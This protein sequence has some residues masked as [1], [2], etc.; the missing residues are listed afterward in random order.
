M[1]STEFRIMGVF[2]LKVLTNAVRIIESLNQRGSNY[3]GLFI[4]N[5]TENL[6]GPEQVIRIVERFDCTYITCFSE[7]VRIVIILLQKFKYYSNS[8]NSRSA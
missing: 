5:C 4:R 1:I 2:S 3:G 6:T 8:F 7:T